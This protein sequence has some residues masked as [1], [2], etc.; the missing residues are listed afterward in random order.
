[1][2]VN[3]QPTPASKTHVF[4]G[5]DRN[6]RVLRVRFEYPAK[7]QNLKTPIFYEGK[8]TR[9]HPQNPQLPAILDPVF[10]LLRV[11]VAIATQA[12][13]VNDLVDDFIQLRCKAP[14]GWQLPFG[15][16]V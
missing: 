7:T 1:M 2:R 3:D 10:K 9:N 5:V 16:F 6:L 14:T 11:A 13:A 4:R 15:F 12:F 8:D